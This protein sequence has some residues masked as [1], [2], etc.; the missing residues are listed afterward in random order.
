MSFDCA[1][2]FFSFNTVSIFSSMIL[3]NIYL[4]NLKE[5]SNNSQRRISI[6]VFSTYLIILTEYDFSLMICVNFFNFS[7][8]ST[9][10]IE[11]NLI[12][13]VFLYLTICEPELMLTKI[14]FITISAL[15][16]L[17]DFDSLLKTI[18]FVKFIIFE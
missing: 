13:F 4:N 9:T 12:N 7:K 5:I 3:Q 14:F 10:S 1:M 16:T 11:L 17:I 8:I 2:I 18:L 6:N 15:K